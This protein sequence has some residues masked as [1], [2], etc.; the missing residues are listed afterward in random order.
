MGQLARVRVLG[1]TLVLFESSAGSRI[2]DTLALWAFYPRVCVWCAQQDAMRLTGDASAG[3]QFTIECEK[4]EAVSAVVVLALIVCNPK[5][6]GGKVP[7][8]IYIVKNRGHYM[9]N[10]V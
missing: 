7:D 5:H 9:K 8:V 10:V 6:V 4:L 3:L 1:H 2:K